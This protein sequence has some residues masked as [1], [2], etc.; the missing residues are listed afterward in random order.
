MWN[1][2]KF[3][4][5]LMFAARAHRNQN[6]FYPEDMPYTVHICSVMQFAIRGCLQDTTKDFDWDLLVQCALLHDVIEDTNVTFEM[7]EKSLVLGL[8]TV[9]LR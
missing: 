6:M 2:Q 7:I 8:Q 5:A 1:N 9:F 4:E 3:V